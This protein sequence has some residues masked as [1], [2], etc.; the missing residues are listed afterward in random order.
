M[1][2]MLVVDDEASMRPLLEIDSG[3]AG[4]EETGAASGRSLLAVHH[5]EIS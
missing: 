5:M 3:K 4:Y 2:R 1:S